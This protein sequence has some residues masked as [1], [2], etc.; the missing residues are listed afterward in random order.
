LKRE[1]G[2]IKR[3]GDGFTAVVGEASVETVGEAEVAISLIKCKRKKKKRL[4][5]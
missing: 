1:A 3:F 4:E 2:E 5:S